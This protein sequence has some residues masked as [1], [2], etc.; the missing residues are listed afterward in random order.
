M[1]LFTANGVENTSVEMI[2][3]ESGLTLR[4][5]QN[6]FRT[7]KDLIAAVLANSYAAELKDMKSMALAESYQ[8]KNG[9]EQIIEIITIACQ[10]AIGKAD[11]IFCTSQMEHILSRA[12]KDNEEVRLEGN[13]NFIMDHIQRAF[14]KGLKDGSITV[15]MKDNLV[16]A[17]SITLALYGIQQQV[18][19]AMCDQRLH[20]V[21][22]PEIAIKK[23][24]R[25]M[26]LM[27]SEK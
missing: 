15:K 13:W 20:E 24:I 21:F 5:V 4:S 26:E 27:L 3:R 7:K 23:Y 25:Q 8:N 22:Q 2:A 1:K 10:K 11:V 16:D 17:N 6:Y 14:T 9:A 18:A 12:S 19:F